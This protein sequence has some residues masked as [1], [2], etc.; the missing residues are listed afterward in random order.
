MT[1]ILKYFR[2]L[3]NITS[4]E[5]ASLAQIDFF[6]FYLS[7][8]YLSK[9]FN[10]SFPYAENYFE[11]W[12]CCYHSAPLLLVNKSILAIW[13]LSCYYYI[14]VRISNMREEHVFEVFVIVCTFVVLDAG[15][16]LVFI[17]FG[18]IYKMN[19]RNLWDYSVQVQRKGSKPIKFHRLLITVCLHGLWEPV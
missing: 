13:L 12:C 17:P 15:Q 9:S 8:I 16:F 3:T 11:S 2:L 5:F 19:G 6:L 10:P 18:F 4:L 1:F 7:A 14:M